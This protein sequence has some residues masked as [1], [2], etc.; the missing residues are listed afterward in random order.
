MRP[1]CFLEVGYA[2]GREL[3]TLLMARK[4]SSL[5][6]DVQTFAGLLWETGGT[7]EDRRRTFREHW[8]AVKNRPPLVAAESLVS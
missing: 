7:V 8:E 6:F 3:H 4:G 5:P 2:L 1:N